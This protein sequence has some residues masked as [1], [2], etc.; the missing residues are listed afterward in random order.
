[1]VEQGVIAAK[2][3]TGEKEG[4]VYTIIR[5]H[6]MGVNPKISDWRS[7]FPNTTRMTAQTE[8]QLEWRYTDIRYVVNVRTEIRT[9]GYYASKDDFNS[10]DPGDA[11]R[12]RI[13]HRR[14]PTI[15]IVRVTPKDAR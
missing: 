8:A 9:M 6:E 15:K 12:F 14:D 5:F 13:L 1:V 10:V 2:A 7:L 11:V 4:S 3:I